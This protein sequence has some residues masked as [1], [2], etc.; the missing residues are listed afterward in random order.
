MF[1]QIIKV[2]LLIDY[3]MGC[4]NAHDNIL[5]DEKVAYLD[6]KMIAN[7]GA[8]YEK[9]LH[10][11]YTNNKINPTIHQVAKVFYKHL[12]LNKK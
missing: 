12:R 2:S 7:T 6:K 11:I 3:F 4:F 1:N 10:K 9:L 5:Y 8:S